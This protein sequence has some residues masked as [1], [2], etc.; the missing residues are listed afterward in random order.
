[1][2]FDL[3]IPIPRQWP[4]QVKTTFLQAINIVSDVFSIPTTIQHG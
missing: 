2:S 3:D 4:R 1:M